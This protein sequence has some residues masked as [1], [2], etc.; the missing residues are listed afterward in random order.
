MLDAATPRLGVIRCIRLVLAG[1]V[2]VA[3]VGLAQAHPFDGIAKLW[4]RGSFDSAGASLQ[5]H[6]EKHGREVDATS[7]ESYARKAEA[8]YL[9]VK[10]DPWGS[11]RPV[12]GE[13]PEVRRF[14]RGERYMDIY[15]TTGNLRLIISF[16]AR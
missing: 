12:P 3:G 1:L 7:V 11:G 9:Q 16:G 14:A 8:L 10:G 13:T 2:I 5:W 6:F 4:D 15:R